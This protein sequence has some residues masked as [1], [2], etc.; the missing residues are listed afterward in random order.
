MDRANDLMAAS[1]M[2]GWSNCGETALRPRI[3]AD[4]HGRASSSLA[5]RVDEL[6]VRMIGGH[7]TRPP[8]SLHPGDMAD[9]EA[10]SEAGDGAGHAG[11]GSVWQK[12]RDGSPD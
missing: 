10:G 4:D 11:R 6:I 3:E 12:M 5:R 7:R 9:R 8:V 2:E 1:A